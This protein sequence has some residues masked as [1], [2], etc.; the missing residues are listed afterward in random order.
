MDNLIEWNKKINL[1]AIKEEKDIIVKHFIDS[2]LIEKEV[3]G[4]KL[5]DILFILFHPSQGSLML[6]LMMSCSETR[7]Q[8]YLQF[9]CSLK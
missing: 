6:C 2:I 8:R 7:T 1:T 9:H 3:I 5:I 4:N